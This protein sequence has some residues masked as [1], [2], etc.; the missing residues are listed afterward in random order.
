M[1]NSDSASTPPS[2]ITGQLRTRRAAAKRRLKRPRTQP[3][4]TE[5]TRLRLIEAAAQILRRKGY[6]GLRIAEV[7]KIARVS[8][9]GQI[10]HFPTKDRL[11]IA[12]AEHLFR[13]SLDRGVARARE[14]MATSVDPI[15]AIIQ[16]SLDF[17]FGEDFGVALDLVLTSGKSRGL[18][19]RIFAH[20]RKNRLSVEEAWLNVLLARGL[21]R[22][23]AEQAL[24]L[25][26]S[27]VRGLSIR[28]LWQSD[29]ELFRSLLDSWKQ[30]LAEHLDKRLASTK[31]RGPH[32]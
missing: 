29:E 6:A 2:A 16:D 18:R 12:T 25:T 4:R 17:F 32:E 22:A 3:E 9:G 10:H 28:A 11:V 5:E 27:I 23:E 26:I 31:R 20:A 21:P 30:M 14:A 13:K 24:W 19:E 8:R 7:S 1:S 15:E